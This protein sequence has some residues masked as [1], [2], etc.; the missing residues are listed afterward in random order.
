M[1]AFL[2]TYLQVIEKQSNDK[3]VIKH[4][5]D[6]WYLSDKKEYDVFA[7]KYAMNGELTKQGHKIEAMD[8][9]CK[10]MNIHATPTIFINGYQLPD[11]YNIED[12]Q[13]FLLE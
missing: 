9:S 1:N 12:L 10:A 13:Y 11:A 4:A 3:Q 8:N 7:V 2:V 6:D 5:L